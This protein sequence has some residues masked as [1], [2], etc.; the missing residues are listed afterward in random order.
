MKVIEH[1]WKWLEKHFYR[2]QLTASKVSLLSVWMSGGSYD[3]YVSVG[4]IY[5]LVNKGKVDPTAWRTQYGEMFWAKYWYLNRQYQP[6]L[7]AHLHRTVGLIEKD[8]FCYNA[9]TGRR[10]LESDL[11]Y[12]NYDIPCEMVWTWLAATEGQ[13]LEHS[14]LLSAYSY[15]TLFSTLAKLVNKDKP[16]EKDAYFFASVVMAMIF[17]I[18]FERY[19]GDFA[20]EADEWKAMYAR[21]ELDSRLYVLRILGSLDTPL[22]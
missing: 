13:S 3:E 20:K 8:P 21:W 15:Q 1:A 7:V 11:D 14:F 16:T 19:Q 6:W 18:G 4:K 12:S 9:E 10:W 17:R 5:L 2:K 22:T